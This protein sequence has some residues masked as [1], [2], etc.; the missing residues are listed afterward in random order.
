M[1]EGC[2]LDHVDRPGGSSCL[3]IF[4]FWD[5]PQGLENSRS[6]DG[7]TRKHNNA[8]IIVQLVMG[9]AKTLN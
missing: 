2:D 9:I 6:V 3:P 1:F 5:Q 4:Y 7:I 8:T